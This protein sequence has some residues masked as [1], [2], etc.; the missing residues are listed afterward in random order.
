MQDV[1]AVHT[2]REFASVF[3][4]RLL[5]HGHVDLASNEARSALLTAKLP[6]ASIPV[7]YL[8]L[9][10]GMLFG[11]RGQ[12]LGERAESFWSILL[13]NIAEGAC[14][15]FLGPGVIQGLLPSPRELAQALASSHNYPFADSDNPPR[16]AQ[17]VGTLDNRRLR[18][19]V[20]SALTTGFKKRMGLPVSPK[21]RRLG[22]SQT[23][24][25]ANWSELGQQLTESEIHHQLADL[26]MP[27]YIT[28]NFDNFMTLALQA[29]L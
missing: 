23:I 1:V 3:Y 12:L 22:L 9:R 2:A 19:D 4:R 5:Q 18:R 10:S 8:R 15:P 25:A 29:S 16:V 27:L 20:V 7:L 21:D 6:G 11:Q 14:T 24:A 28:T 26:D 13:D 17:F